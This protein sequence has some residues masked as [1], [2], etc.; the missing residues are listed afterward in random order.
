MTS[1]SIGI[2]GA[3][4]AGLHLGLFLQQHGIA[5]TL[6]SD[7]TPDQI[8]AGRLPNAPLVFGHTRA[9][10][11]ALGVNHWDDPA[12]DVRS[13]YVRVGGERPLAFRGNLARP[14]ICVDQ[15]LYQAR[16]L[17]D[18]AARGGRVVTGPIA[19][20]D[21]G[22]LAGK[23]ALVVVAAGRGSLAEIFPRVPEHSPYSAP[24]RRLVG[25]IF[26]GITP[27]DPLGAGVTVVP[28][29]GEVIE[30]PMVS[31]DGLRIVLGIEALPGGALEPLTHLRYEDDPR[32]FAD[33]TLALLRQHA[34]DLHARIDPAAFAPTR[35]LDLLQ[36]ALTPVVRRAY[37]RLDGGACVM[38]IGD[39]QALNDPLTGQGANTASHS[40]W[41]LGEAIRE[42]PDGP[43]DEAFC[44]RA[45]GR[46]R[47][48]AD[49]VA[50][51][52][53]MMLQPPAP[54]RLDFMVAAARRQAIADEHVNNFDAPARN[55]AIL[56]TPEGTAAFLH[57]HGV[58]PAP[59]LAAS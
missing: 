13:F 43:F 20:G 15:R 57:R 50:D 25:A 34:P 47:D 6:Y 12:H 46:L 24:Q 38:A 9:R 5:A 30:L 42:R 26:R 22:R 55:W 1:A 56:A 39:V 27:T 8:R 37:A 2:V 52:T 35:P 23:H 32:G 29:H 49:T 45:E 53:N 17:E 48:Y 7:R 36:G 11:R 33:L 40:A 54:H 28:G 44:R 51:Y 16:L 59:A 21:L 41:T 3:G 31:F 19:A 18:F 58:V 10:E 4:I 14:A